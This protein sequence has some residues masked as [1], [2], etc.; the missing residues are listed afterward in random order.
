MDWFTRAGARG[1]VLAA[2]PCCG[3][4][5]IMGTG[6]DLKTWLARV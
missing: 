6:R 2:P 3:T 5:W 1:A 4:A